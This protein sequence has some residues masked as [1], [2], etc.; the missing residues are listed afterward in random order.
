M[1]PQR[2]PAPPP[3]CWPG[4]G[5]AQRAAA[6]G[7]AGRVPIPGKLPIVLPRAAD[8]RGIERAVEAYGL[9][10]A[11]PEEVGMDAYLL[12]RVDSIILAGIL[13]GAAPGAALAVG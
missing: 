4:S 9:D 2:L 11:A 12:A 7:L 5:A 1:R 8:G 3:I 10:I 6:R 13:E